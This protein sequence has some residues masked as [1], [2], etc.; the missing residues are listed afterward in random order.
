MQPAINRQV[1]IDKAV[2]TCMNILY[3]YIYTVYIYICI[4]IYVYTYVY[5]YVYI[6]IYIYIYIILHTY[7]IY[8]SNIFCVSYCVTFLDNRDQEKIMFDNV[9]NR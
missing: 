8:I 7:N 2:I 4:H 9:G 6:Y 3:I 5:I 1:W